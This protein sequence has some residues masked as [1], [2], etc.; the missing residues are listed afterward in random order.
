MITRSFF[1]LNRHCR[2]SF[3]A[4][5]DEAPACPRCT[6][7]RTQWVPKTT[8]TISGKTRQTDR[9]MRDLTAS[10]GMTNYNSPRHGE[11]AMPQVQPTAVKGRTRKW[12]PMPGWSVNLPENAQ[13]QLHDSAYC[14]P[15]GVTAPQKVVLGG[16]IPV[17]KRSATATGAVPLYDASFRPPGGIPR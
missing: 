6:G 14:A 4:V 12:E 7:A 8:G 11:R 2:H 17:D 1:C 10:Y 15:T 5:D 13:G 3:D 16:S 9:D